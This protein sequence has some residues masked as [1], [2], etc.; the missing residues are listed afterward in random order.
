M[1][2]TIL[3]ITA[4]LA[5]SGC[6]SISERNAKNAADLRAGRAAAEQ[7]KVIAAQVREAIRD[8]KPAQ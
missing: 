5:L 1:K 2:T 4:A 6:A 8:I 3:T 7:A